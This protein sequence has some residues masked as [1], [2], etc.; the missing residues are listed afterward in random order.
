[1]S[2]AATGS[3]KDSATFMDDLAKH[4]D[5]LEEV[6]RTITGKVDGID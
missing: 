3:G 4:L 1:M 6:L 2:P 5:H